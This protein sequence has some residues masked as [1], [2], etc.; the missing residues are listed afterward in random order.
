MTENQRQVIHDCAHRL[1]S[2][3]TYIMLCSHTMK[4]DL[5]NRLSSEHEEEF[6]KMADALEATRRDLNILLKQF[7][8]TP[9]KGEV[10]AG[11][12][13]RT[14]GARRTESEDAA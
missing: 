14:I 4:L 7:E 2:R 8:K 5:H 6:R 1:R 3:L 11:D 9:K 13:P 12:E 10:Q